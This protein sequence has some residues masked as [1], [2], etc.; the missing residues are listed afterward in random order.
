MKR[1]EEFYHYLPTEKA[2]IIPILG[3]SPELLKESAKKSICDLEKIK[4]NTLLNLISKALGFSGGFAGFKEEYESKLLLFLETNGFNHQKKL[5]IKNEF[6]RFFNSDINPRTLSDR[7]F[8]SSLPIPNRIFYG[9]NFDF[10]KSSPKEFYNLLPY[11]KSFSPSKPDKLKDEIF[12]N[13]IMRHKDIATLL[14]QLNCI[15]YG[16][17]YLGDQF[18]EY[19]NMSLN[20]VLK[21]YHRDLQDKEYIYIKD[22]AEKQ[23]ICLRSIIEP[24]K[25]CWLT[26]IPYNENLIFLKDI[27]GNYDFLFRGLRDKPF[28]HNPISEYTK[29]QFLPKSNDAYHHKRWLYYKYDGWLDNDQHQAELNHYKQDIH[30]SNFDNIAKD[31]FI[32][33]SL[34][35]PPAKP[36]KQADG[37]HEIFINDMTYCIS[38]LITIKDF[39]AFAEENP[40]YFALRN[41]NNSDKLETVNSDDENL[42]AS[43]TWFDANA[44]ARWFSDKNGIPVRLLSNDEY[45]SIAPPVP[46]NQENTFKIPGSKYYYWCRP[47]GSRLECE[48]PPYMHE[49]DFQ[50]LYLK[51]KTDAMVWKQS[52]SG[53]KF[54]ISPRFGE[55][56]NDDAISREAPAISTYDHGALTLPSARADRCKFSASSTGKYKSMKIGFR[57]CYLSSNNNNVKGAQ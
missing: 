11:T 18:I 49:Q 38:D 33:N 2:H 43:V 27:D 31:Y 8:Q 29:N 12:N 7:L 53:V 16:L 47:D 4:H 45:I 25:E 3:L 57:L 44:Y 40:D 37:F 50:A 17:N 54:L 14:V 42:P 46:D 20:I 35:V 24:L 5:L 6:S 15:A 23:I 34:Y 39:F 56:L 22:L 41:N 1:Q 26:V 32:K 36:F 10:S 21:L 52:S 30:Y 9:N 19:N 48:H 28:I 13:F 55:W 51:Y